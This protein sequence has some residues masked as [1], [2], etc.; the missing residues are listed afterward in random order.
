M[1]DLTLNLLSGAHGRP[2]ILFL[3][4]NIPDVILQG[5]ACRTSSVPDA[6]VPETHTHGPTY[7]AIGSYPWAC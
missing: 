1:K 7:G 2:P 3:G 5:D 6:N 4:W